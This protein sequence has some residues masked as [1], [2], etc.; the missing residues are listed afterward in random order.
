MQ[1]IYWTHCTINYSISLSL[2]PKRLHIFIS[3]YTLLKLLSR[4]NQHPLLTSFCRSWAV[5]DRKSHERLMTTTVKDTRNFYTRDTFLYTIPF[6]NLEGIAI[7]SYGY[8]SPSYFQNCYK[9]VFFHLC[10]HPFSLILLFLH[11]SS[12]WGKWQLQ[13]GRL[14][15]QGARSFN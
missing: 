13:N 2:T 6:Y 12:F 14:A 5:H 15:S 7:P 4:Q 3:S 9:S 10:P 1:F 8:P 11:E